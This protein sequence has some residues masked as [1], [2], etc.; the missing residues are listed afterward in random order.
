[1][2]PAIPILFLLIFLPSFFANEFPQENNIIILSNSTFSDALQTFPKLFVFFEGFANRDSAKLFNSFS[3]LANEK[4]NHP[5]LS[6]IQFAKTNLSETLDLRVWQNIKGKD[7]NLIR[8]YFGSSTQDYIGGRNVEEILNWIKRKVK[9][10]APKSK[11]LFEVSE[12]ANLIESKEIV[13]FFIGSTK[14]EKFDLYRH[15]I[16]KYDY[17]T[18][19]HSSAYWAYEDFSLPSDNI[20]L[21]CINNF[22]KT[23]TTFDR[24]WNNKN[25]GIFF[26]VF[27]Q[28][29]YFTNETVTFPTFERLFFGKENFILLAMNTSSS[30]SIS[31]I[32]EYK[33]SKWFLG[34]KI[35]MM[36]VDAYN[37]ED[38][39]FK[40]LLK[41]FRMELQDVS[42]IPELVLFDRESTPGQ[43]TKYKMFGGIIDASIIYFY[44]GWKNKEIEPFWKSLP[45]PL[46]ENYGQ[47]IDINVEL[48][49]E[50]VLNNTQ[51]VIVIY[52][53]KGCAHCNTTKDMIKSVAEKYAKNKNLLFTMM[54]IEQNDTPGH[55]FK[56]IPQVFLYTSNHKE[57]GLQY[58]LK[59]EEEI[60]ISF[61]K[62]HVT[63]PWVVADGESKTDL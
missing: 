50:K 49:N 28:K 17:L 51:D 38:K 30:E 8:L 32:K 12:L 4:E 58:K 34:N 20:S 57:K 7:F 10:S 24:E 1:M 45:E 36:M 9:V 56:E 37:P 35:I 26:N 61:L 60:F 33:K 31:A 21:I 39:I 6:G 43:L 11:E 14:N 62:E 52:Y 27:S 53:D 41:L 54:D 40:S 13:F 18:F 22:D 3:K 23:N 25:L 47:I 19:A 5:N 42:E 2:T 55:E 16:E 63:Y 48:F 15:V 44:K 29:S 59:Y 46:L